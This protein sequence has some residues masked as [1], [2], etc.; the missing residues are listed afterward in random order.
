MTENISDNLRK[1]FKL[2]EATFY[3]RKW[4]NMREGCHIYSWIQFPIFCDTYGFAMKFI[5]L[6]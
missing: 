5:N 6:P 3:L 2:K 1:N 4:K